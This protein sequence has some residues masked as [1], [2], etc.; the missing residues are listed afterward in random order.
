VGLGLSFGFWKNEIRNE[1]RERAW[2]LNE[3]KG[4][5]GCGRNRE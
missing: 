3:I 5:I 4:K 2:I 1:E